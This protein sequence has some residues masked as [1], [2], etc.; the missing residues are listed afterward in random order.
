MILKNSSNQYYGSTDITRGVLRYAELRGISS[1]K[2]LKGTGLTK[3][4]FEQNKMIYTL[5]T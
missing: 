5:C 4:F 2:I 1:D 3:E